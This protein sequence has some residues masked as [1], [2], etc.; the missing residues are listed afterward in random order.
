MADDGFTLLQLTAATRTC[1]RAML[2]H[3]GLR[4]WILMSLGGNLMESISNPAS[5]RSTQRMVVAAD[6]VL[7]APLDDLPKAVIAKGNML[8]GII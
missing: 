6:A 5:T 3:H 1:L 7:E 2:V 4:L 8:T